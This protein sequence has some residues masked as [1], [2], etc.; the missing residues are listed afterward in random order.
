MDSQ[1]V[2]VAEQTASTNANNSTATV[3]AS[4]PHDVQCLQA[5]I[6]EAQRGEGSAC[7]QLLQQFRPLIRSRMHRLWSWLQEELS[8]VEWDDIES[9]VRFSFLSRLRD[10]RASQG[11]FFAHYIKQMLDAD[12]RTYLRQQRRQAALPFSQI[13]L[14]ANVFEGDE[15]G[16]GYSPQGTGSVGACD[17]THLL[18]Q[19]LSLQ[20]ALETLTAAQ[21]EVIW[22]CCVLGHTE[23]EAATQLNLSRSAVRNRLESALA[24]LRAFFG[25]HNF[26]YAEPCNE[27]STSL[28][29]RT[30]RASSRTAALQHEFWI[31]RI[32]MA[33]DDKRPDL[34][35]VG[36]G[37]PILLQGVF[38]FEETGLK[39][40]R[41]LSQKLSYTVPPGCVLGVRY[42]R[43]GVSCERMVCVSTVVNGAP[44]RLV[45]VAA[46]SSIHV[47]FAIVE[48]IVAGSQ[49]EIHIASEA[50]GIAI[51][52]VGCLQM[53]A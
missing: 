22:R 24:R 30:G 41:L 43:V 1:S 39:S 21:R 46:N 14:Y 47:P 27:H 28:A 33:K 11:V 29:T 3:E 51:V 2:E 12:C 6:K 9:H 49:I 26:E 50:P 31:G 7:E 42:F 34:V 18:E 19:N 38:E 25:E 20:A 44:H 32:N 13:G 16:D 5:L 40:P 4:E 17:T 48:P 10:Y 23:S 8:N 36:G 15:L 52:D 53:P 35:G 45:P 37:R